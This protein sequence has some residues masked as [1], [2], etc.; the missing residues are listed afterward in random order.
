MEVGVLGG[1]KGNYQ[2]NYSGNY[3]LLRKRS[4]NEY[5]LV[6]STGLH[7]YSKR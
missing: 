5:N 7:T 1:E 2:T 3:S 4:S 6:V